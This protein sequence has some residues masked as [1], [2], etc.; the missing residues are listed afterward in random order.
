MGVPGLA[1]GLVASAIP[2]MTAAADGPR[3][4]V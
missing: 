1:P 3:F 2:T 4:N